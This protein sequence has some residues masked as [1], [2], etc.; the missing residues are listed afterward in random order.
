[1]ASIETC[2]AIQNRTAATA[3]AK[4]LVSHTKQSSNDL[5]SRDRR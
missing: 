5:S 1:M 2:A 4:N 3:N